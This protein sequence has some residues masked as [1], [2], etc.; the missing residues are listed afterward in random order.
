MTRSH[1]DLGFGDPDGRRDHGHDDE[2]QVL[3]GVSFDDSFR[4]AEFLLAV[5]HLHQ[6][7]H[8]SLKDAVLV[9]KTLDGNTHV[10]ETTDTPPGPAALTGAMWAGLVGFL[11]GGPVGWVVGGVVGA[12]VG[13]GTAHF[14][15]LG[16]PDEWVE[17]FRSAVKPGTTSVLLLVTQ[18]RPGPF[19]NEAER[20]PGAH[21]VYANLDAGRV[22]R[23]KEAFHDTDTTTTTELETTTEPG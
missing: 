22:Q 4:A 7:Q 15:D 13:A 23:L 16:V 18:L 3:V 6:Q 19:A 5:R 2:P 14:V 1:F 8:L 9:T 20:F 12:G 10:Q 11:I 17:W 21:L